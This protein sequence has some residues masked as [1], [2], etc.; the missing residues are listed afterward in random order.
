MIDQKLAEIIRFLGVLDSMTPRRENACLSLHH[1][2]FFRQDTI[3][4]FNANGHIS[5]SALQRYTHTTTTTTVVRVALH[6]GLVCPPVL[7]PAES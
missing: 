7:R 6:D 1:L 4:Q 2:F 3:N 5:I